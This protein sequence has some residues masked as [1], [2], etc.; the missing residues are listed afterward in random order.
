MAGNLGYELDLTTLDEEEKQEIREQIQA[1]KEQ[2]EL[3]HYGTYYRVASTMAGDAYG[4]WA[5]V[6]E[7]KNKALLSV[8]SAEA[9]ANRP[10]YYAKCPGLKEDGIYHCLETDGV[11]SGA[12]LRYVGIAIPIV[13]EEYFARQ[14]HLNEV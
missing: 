11:Y 13:N 7:E 9:R 1:Y 14:Y 4:A 5:F 10:I 12:T 6:N 3:I 2:W 8:V